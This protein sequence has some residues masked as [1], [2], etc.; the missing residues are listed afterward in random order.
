MNNPIVVDTHVLLWALLQPEE[1]T[2]EIK[3][4]ITLAQENSRLFISSISLWEIAMLK[5][6]KRIN[7]YEP[8]K[9]FL[10]SITNINGI[11]IKDISP[12]IAAESILL[13]DNFHGDPADRIIVATA[14]CYGAML[15]TRD[16]KILT[17]AELGHIK[18]Q[19]A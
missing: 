15:L 11:S 19:L 17:W 10:E 3:H 4:Q 6:K 14:K 18:V 1:L 5:F 7:I 2:E 16:Q 9:D 12:E 13:M 8:I